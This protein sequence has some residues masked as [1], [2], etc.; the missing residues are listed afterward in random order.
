MY[1]LYMNNRKEVDMEEGWD[2]I[3]GEGWDLIEGD[4]IAI[5]S[6]TVLI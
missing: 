5:S 6:N 3:S 4:G 1:N 2:D